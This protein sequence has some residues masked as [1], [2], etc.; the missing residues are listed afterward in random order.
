MTAIPSVQDVDLVKRVFLECWHEFHEWKHAYSTSELAKLSGQ[1]KVEGVDPNPET[2]LPA[3]EDLDDF[4]YG[5]DAD[6]E[7]AEIR[8]WQFDT[9][10]SAPSA[11]NVRATILTGPLVKHKAEDDVQ[12]VP[13]YEACVPIAQSLS[14]TDT[15][16][17]NEFL[18]F[19]PFADEPE[20]A[21]EFPSYLYLSEERTYH[22]VDYAAG[23][24]QW[25]D[26]AWQDMGRN[27]DGMMTRHLAWSCLSRAGSFIFQRT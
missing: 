25:L 5:S 9:D 17:E 20:F 22:K 11:S 12:P 16:A 27:P 26:F 18:E 1:V 24:R 15:P 13:P 2:V 4:D 10:A 23:D 14:V 6:E 19:L 3:E 21:R 7:L 8:I